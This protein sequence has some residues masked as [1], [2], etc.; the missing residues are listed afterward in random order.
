MKR[1]ALF[2]VMMT[3]VV[4]TQAQTARRMTLP[5][6]DDGAAQLTCF[7]PTMPSGRAVVDCPGGGYSHLSMDKEGLDWADYFNARGIA[8][9]VLK[10]RMPQGDRSIPMSDAYK[11]MR[12]VRDSAEQWK[13]NPMDVGIMG[14]SAG[15]HLAS[16]VST[17]APADCRPDFS[18]LFYPV[19]S[20][21]EKETHK[22]SVVNFLG[23]GRTDEKLQKEFSNHLQVKPFR[24]PPAIILLANDD[25]AVPPVTNG[26]AYYSAMRNAGNECALYIYPSGGHG[27]GKRED[28]KYCQQMLS[29][30][31]TWLEGLPSPR[32]GAQ[33]VACIGNSITAGSGIAMAPVNGYPA[34]LQKLLGRDYV[35]KN[36]GVSGRTMLNKGDRPYMKNDAWREALAFQPQIVVIKL[37]TNDTKPK[38]WVHGD[39]FR[40]DMQAMIDTLKALPTQPKIY[41]A[42]PVKAFEN[43]FGIRDSVI[44]NEVIPIIRKVAKKNKL[45]VIDLH[46]TIADPQLLNSDGV[47]PNTKGAGEMAKIIAEAIKES[48]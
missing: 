27:F 38:N 17:H 22:G 5:I 40:A 21:V 48:K 1:L 28:F 43:R 19:I 26:V 24:T 30:L 47:H 20:M 7:L 45:Q 34:Q 42:L 35:V 14:F 8:Y 11:A 36:F 31:S 16:T 18:I 9:F 6:S 37:G 41:L 39:E 3:A 32:M 13:I 29:D 12:L 25:R 10:Y 44:E 2:L 4:L 46:S 15:G 33:R 23:D